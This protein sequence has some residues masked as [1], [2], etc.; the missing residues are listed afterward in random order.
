MKKQS[1]SYHPGNLMNPFLE[2]AEKRSNLPREKKNRLLPPSPM[3]RTS[4]GK[5]EDSSKNGMQM[6][7]GCT[8]EKGE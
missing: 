5:S 3:N 2:E 6:C 1:I 8:K 7:P 4:H